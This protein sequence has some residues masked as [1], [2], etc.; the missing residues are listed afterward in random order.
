MIDQREFEVIM[1]KLEI[2]VTKKIEEKFDE[3][4]NIEIRNMVRTELDR[5][6]TNMR[7][8]VRK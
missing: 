1:Q 4:A 2:L 6:I 3:R 8:L 5:M 7:E